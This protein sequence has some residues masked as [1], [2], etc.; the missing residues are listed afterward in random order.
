MYLLTFYPEDVAELKARSENDMEQLESDYETYAFLGEL[1]QDVK[2]NLKDVYEGDL[3]QKFYAVLVD[4]NN[5]KVLKVYE[6][7]IETKIK[8]VKT[9]NV[10]E[11]YILED[12]DISEGWSREYE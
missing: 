2:M 1:V 7:A 10:S 6:F 5:G 4:D 3:Y 12:D 8:R 9:E 11:D